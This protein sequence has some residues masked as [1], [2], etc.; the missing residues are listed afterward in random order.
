[1]D[2]DWVAVSMACITFRRSACRHDVTKEKRG[3]R[4]RENDVLVLVCLQITW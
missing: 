1:M 3:Q 2:A 4:I